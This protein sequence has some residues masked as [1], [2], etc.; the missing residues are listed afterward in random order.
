M[1]FESK[2]SKIV[3]RDSTGNL[4]QML[5]ETDASQVSYGNT[6]VQSTLEQF[7]SDLANATENAKEVA[8]LNLEPNSENTQNLNADSIIFW[9]TAEEP[10][11]PSSNIP[12][13]TSGNQSIS[14]IKT[15][16]AGIF[17]GTTILE[18]DVSAFDCSTASSF[19]KTIE[20]NTALSFVNVPSNVTCC[21]TVILKNGGNYNVEWPTSVKWSGN[22]VPTLTSNGTDV[23]SFVTVTG[24][25]IWYGT[26]LCT[27][28][29]E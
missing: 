4:V 6:T 27:G 20:S 23:F 17:S 7:S 19:T 25:T 10:S 21:I 3:V 1:S 29:I 14:G 12:V 18:S 22:A 15:F 24:G 2:K 16:T 9:S 26:P 13:F 28:I 11:E 5:P 8:L